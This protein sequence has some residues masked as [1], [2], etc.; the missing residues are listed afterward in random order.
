MREII[1]RGKLSR[2]ITFLFRM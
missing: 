1:S 2:K